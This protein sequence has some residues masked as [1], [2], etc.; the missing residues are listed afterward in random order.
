MA[1]SDFFNRWARR[2]ADSSFPDS[3]N[4][5][6]G[7]D[8]E[9]GDTL[10]AGPEC[11]RQSTSEVAAPPVEPPAEPPP[12][13]TLE[14][15]ALL[16]TDG[17]FVPFMAAGVD[18]TVRRAA[19]KKLFADPQFNIMDGLDIYVGDY[20]N[21]ETMPASMLHQLNHAKDLLDPLGTLERAAQCAER[22]RQASLALERSDAS[23]D[24]GDA[25]SADASQADATLLPDAQVASDSQ[26]AAQSE[27]AA[28]ALPPSSIPDTDTPSTP[29]PSDTRP[30]PATDA[31]GIATDGAKAAVPRDASSRGPHE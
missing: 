21:M 24:T 27:V 13:P 8:T 22:E 1:A 16:T 4:A 10:P 31:T 28:A 9:Q 20:S 6:A 18:D 19:L 3:A 23:D 29:E 14:D 30:T 25:S 17:N 7:L 15:A 12:L 2:N 11:C 26:G 5:R